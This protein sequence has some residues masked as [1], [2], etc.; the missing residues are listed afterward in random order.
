MN[1]IIRDLSAVIA[2]TLLFLCTATLSDAQRRNDRE[3]RDAVRS[4]NSKLDDLEMDLRYR[5]QSTSVPSGQT[6]GAMDQIRDLRD[7]VH[8]FEENLYQRRENVEDVN[9]LINA[10]RPVGIFLQ[11]EPQNRRVDE[12]WTGV[13]RQIE[14]IAS[15][16]GIT[17]NWN[18]EDLPQPVGDQQW[19][20]AKVGQAQSVGLSGT[21]EL[22]RSR[23]EN[24][25]DIVTNENL[26]SEQRQDLHDKLDAPQQ[27][28]LDVRGSQVT[29][30]TSNASPITF[31]ADGREK[32]EQNQQGKEVRV[33]A[34]LSGD[35]LIVSSLGGDTDYTITFTSLSNGRSMKVQRR[36][37]TEYLNQ[38]VIAESIYNKTDAVAQ[39]GIDP[40]ARAQAPPSSSDPAGS[41]SDNDNSGNVVNGGTPTQ[42]GG[43]PRP[44]A[45]PP[46]N[47]TVP[48]GTVLTGTL[49]NEINT[50]ASQNNDRFRMTVQ[51]PNEF[52]G[53]VIE[54]YIS[55]VNRSGKVSGEANVTFNFQRI[56][57]RGGQTYDFAGY[58]QGITDQRGKVIKI[59]NES[60]VR[61]DSQ[62]RE[63]VKRGGIGGGI[64]AVIGAIAGGAKGAAIGA[65]IG[66][67]AGAGSVYAQGRDDI[68]LLPGS[69]ITVQATAPANA[70]TPR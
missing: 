8:D 44:S 34:T 61:G 70:N 39:L 43:A 56:T 52:R 62:T 9:Q 27:I 2:I 51:S 17:P 57:L 26:G 10:A 31:V 45:P 58:L 68:R 16:Y 64:G 36:I 19:P 20:V 60:T 67:G 4:L 41:Y 23:S 22:D 47:Y 37:T 59:D 35:D 1:H 54:G 12:D 29:L 15:N 7:A 24:I 46:G 5:M 25:D 14:R 50:K 11:T 32:T 21:Y 30:A 3:I 63:T 69:T 66:G 55:N 38:T 33:R 65:I 6:S 28:A 18:A 49:E 13:K 53:A 42:P 40:N 48:N